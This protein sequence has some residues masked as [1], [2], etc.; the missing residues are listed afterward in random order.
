MSAQIIDGK[1]FAANL[2]AELS[3]QVDALNVTPGLAV[4]LVGEDP[5]SQVYVRN[6]IK[7]CRS[8]GITSFEHVLPADASQEDVQSTIDKLNEDA[9]VHGILLQLP[10]PDHLDSDTLVQSISPAKDV[11]GLSFVNQGETGRR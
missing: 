6:K 10:V 3:A 8:C 4:I 5:A 11:D 1:A 7:A 2:R 9:G